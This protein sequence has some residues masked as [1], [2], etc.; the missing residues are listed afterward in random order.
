MAKKIIAHDS[1]AWKYNICINSKDSRDSFVAFQINFAFFVND[2][3]FNFKK[4][5]C[6]NFRFLMIWLCGIFS[7]SFIRIPCVIELCYFGE[8]Q[9]SA[10]NENGNNKCWQ[11]T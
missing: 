8:M 7:I 4:K 1:F 6:S 10:W 3:F 2:F 5:T 9:N 11:N